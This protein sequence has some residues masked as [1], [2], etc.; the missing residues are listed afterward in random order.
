MADQ[1]LPEYLAIP[2][3]MRL[4][5]TTFLVHYRQQGVPKLMTLLQPGTK[6]DLAGGED[7]V[8]LYVPVKDLVPK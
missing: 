5:L 1:P 6:L 8:Q 2:G 3:G 4:R 7:F